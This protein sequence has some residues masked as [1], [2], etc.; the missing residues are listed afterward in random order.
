MGSV[1]GP[2]SVWNCDEMS[3][4]RLSSTAMRRMSIM[5]MLASPALPTSLSALPLPRDNGPLA[6]EGDISAPGIASVDVTE[7]V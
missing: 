5:S 2:V 1:L 3:S 7:S 6:R 4:L